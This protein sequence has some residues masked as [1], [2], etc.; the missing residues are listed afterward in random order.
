M[1][2]SHKLGRIVKRYRKTS[3]L[4]LRKLA[5]RVGVSFSTIRNIENGDDFNTQT[6][7]GLAKA[8]GPEFREELALGLGL[9]KGGY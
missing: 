6:L 7:R 5:L 2:A 8:L 1:T 4:S 9:K 3:G